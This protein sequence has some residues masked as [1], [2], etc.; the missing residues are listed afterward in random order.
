[1][2]AL[3]RHTFAAGLVLAC[4]SCP[5]LAKEKWTGSTDQLDDTWAQS[6]LDDPQ[7]DRGWCQSCDQDWND[8]RVS[9]CEVRE[10]AFP[11]GKRPIAIR[12]GDNGGMTVMGWDRDSVRIVYRVTARANTEERAA[13]LA[14]SIR[15]AIASGWLEPDGP[16]A[17]RSEWWSVEVKAWVP[18]S[19]QLALETEN[20]PLGVRG[21]KGTMDLNTTNGPMSLVDLGGAVE[22]RVQNGPLNV[23]L[24]GS[25]WDGTGLDAEA[26]NGPLN[27]SL[28]AKYSA[29]LVTGTISGPRSFEYAIERGQRG[30]W[31]ETTLGKG[32]KR[33]RVVTHNGP[34]HIEERNP[35]T[36][37]PV[38]S[39]YR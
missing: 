6:A 27:L 33:V 30:E 14:S 34:F 8:G 31:I 2:R 3:V 5:A 35:P 23:E 24:A 16:E 38:N 22:A 7:M 21:V 18:R 1:M 4:L 17:T 11:R 9:H 32:G 39:L 10:F 15:L 37:A 19:S 29:E 36:D 20:G 28:P 13:A 25:Q 12:G 26:Q